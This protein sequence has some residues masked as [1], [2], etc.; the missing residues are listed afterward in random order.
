VDTHALSR[1]SQSHVAYE[2]FGFVRSDR[3]QHQRPPAPLDPPLA[4]L[5]VASLPGQS[6][7][8]GLALDPT[9]EELFVANNGDNSVTVYSRTASGDT[10]PLRKLSGA[11]TGLSG[12]SGIPVTAST[13]KAVL[14]T[15]APE[16]V[17][18]GATVTFTWSAG[19]GLTAYC[20]FVGTTLGNY[21]LFRFSAL[22]KA[23]RAPEFLITST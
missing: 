21:D 15:P 19:S 16:T 4:P 23:G 8:P 11:A 17:L 9:N 10:D 12:P 5:T 22:T 2:R 13:R 6:R 20:L 3:K 1:A 14:L 18:A 7:R